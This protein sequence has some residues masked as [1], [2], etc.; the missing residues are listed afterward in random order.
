MVYWFTVSIEEINIICHF[1]LTIKVC[2]SYLLG[3]GKMAQHREA[4][5]YMPDLKR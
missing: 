3:N 1:I 2:R 5:Q 4:P